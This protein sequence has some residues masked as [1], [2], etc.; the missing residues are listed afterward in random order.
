MPA[1]RIKMLQSTILSILHI[2]LN[3]DHMSVRVH[4]IYIL[5]VKEN[6]YKV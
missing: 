1:I 4:L 6:V 3:F 5:F 2:Y